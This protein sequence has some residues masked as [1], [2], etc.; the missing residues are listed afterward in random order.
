MSDCPRDLLYA[1]SHEW[2]Q[3]NHDGTAT[4]GISA[5]A[6]EAMGELVF[7]EMP[8]VGTELAL[9]NDAG[10]IESVKTASDYY[11]PVSG[12][13]VA[14]NEALEEA[15]GIVNEDPYGEGWLFKIT[16]TDAEVGKAD[17]L[18]AAAYQDT[19]IEE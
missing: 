10:V 3:D 8:E 15:P 18:D 13:V 12:E 17:L 16:L 2:L 19:I 9:G 5:H 6:A 4:V 11:S 7:V 1:E 14:I